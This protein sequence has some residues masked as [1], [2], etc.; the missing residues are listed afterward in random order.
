[1][2]VKPIWILTKQEITRWQ[3]HQL[4]YMQIMSFMSNNTVKILSPLNYHH[5][6]TS[7]KLTHF[8]SASECGQ[9]NKGRCWRCLETDAT[10]LPAGTAV[11]SWSGPLSSELYGRHNGCGRSPS[12][13]EAEV[14]NVGGRWSPD[15]RRSDSDQLPSTADLEWVSDDECT[16][17][18]AV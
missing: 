9:D 16:W 14:L 17:W 11:L 8:L 12:P 15:D 4:D 1:M 13:N 6:S 7:N 5:L 2:K 3:R 18:W 10:R